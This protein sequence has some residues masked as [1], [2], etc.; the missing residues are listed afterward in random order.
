MRKT[1]IACCAAALL[2]LLSSAAEQEYV[3]YV[4]PLYT[5]RLKDSQGGYNQMMSK[6]KVSFE[7]LN[8]GLRNSQISFEAQMVYPMEVAHIVESPFDE[9]GSLWNQ[10]RNQDVQGTWT[11]YT[12]QGADHLSYFDS[13]GAGSGLAYVP[14]EFAFHGGVGN[15]VFRHE[16]GH[17]F[18]CSHSDGFQTSVG[19]TIMN[20][21]SIP[22]FSNPNVTYQGV[23]LGDATHN[24]AAKITANRPSSAGRRALNVDAASLSTTWFLIA[25][26]SSQ[27][28]DV[29]GG[30]TSPGTPII[31]W[32]P[33][34]GANQQWKF[35]DFSGGASTFERSGSGAKFVSFTANANGTGATLQNWATG[36]Q[37]Y[38]IEEQADGFSRVRRDDGTGVLD[39]PGAS[40]TQGTQLIQ[41]TWGGGNNQRFKPVQKVD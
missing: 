3:T 17:N 33:H 40:Q 1:T 28:V 11:A 6:M 34:Y 39:V 10:I 9:F 30:A 4:K 22:Y 41:Y 37:R 38:F 21:N 20:G 27:A 7:M 31:Q 25:K 5:T 32:S 24:S 29:Q 23:A 12:T 35:N 26:H 36:K 2:P 19:N 8:T 16:M 14:G 15:T 18:S 13:V